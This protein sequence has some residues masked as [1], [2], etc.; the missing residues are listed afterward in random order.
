[1]DSNVKNAR[2]K[3]YTFLRKIQ[4]IFMDSLLVNLA[5]FLA[6]MF[7]T[8]VSSIYSNYYYIAIKLAPFM[9][10]ISITVFA[11]FKFYRILWRHAT[12]NDLFNI[13]LANM[14]ASFATYIFVVILRL[15][16]VDYGYQMP[17]VAFLLTCFFNIALTGGV[18]M[19]FRMIIVKDISVIKPDN[20]KA[21]YRNA[22]IIGASYMGASVV[23]GM[24]R[25]YYGDI[26]PVVIIDDHPDRIGASMDGIPIVTSPHDLKHLVEKYEI[27]EIVI[28]IITPQGDYGELV[29]KCVET[30]C[31]VRR[32]SPLEETKAIGNSKVS[33]QDIDVN[34]LLGRKESQL[35]TQS[36]AD[37][38][39]GKTVLISGG[40][41]SIGGE[42]CRIL[43]SLSTSP[44]QIILYDISENYMYD[45]YNE[46]ARKYGAKYIASVL[47]LRVGSVRDEFRLSK[48]FTQYKPEIV[49]H[50]AAHKHV[51]LMEDSPFEAIKNNV[52]GTYNIAKI[53]MEYNV[54]RFLLV[55]TDKAVNPTN[56]MGATKRMA[57]MIL[58]S[59]K[60]KS[61]TDFV[62]VR[63]GNVLG[64]HGSVV[65]LFM[66]QINSGGPITLTH[67][68]IIRYFM[69]IP[70]A[71]SLVL[72]AMA[73]ADGGELFVLD[74]GSPVKI[75]TLAERM[76]QLYSN[77][78]EIEIVY[79]GL[80]PGE[81]LYEELLLPKE[82]VIKTSNKQ[83]FI[84]HPEEFDQSLIKSM[85]DELSNAIAGDD[86]T[87]LRKIIKKYVPTY[88]NKN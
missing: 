33:L 79:T 38:V 11:F 10:I 82:G 32:I 40:G 73:L 4:W 75:K 62:A 35:D 48:I 12:T 63:F 68:E 14:V 47:I 58:S 67:P 1:M 84:T 83:I 57:E 44:K 29:D 45:L 17:D 50:A 42:L 20:K 88:V 86:E 51:P 25:G 41:G 34:D 72:Q 13:I 8:A 54:K 31:K 30:G 55:S 36:V 15:L 22:L 81:K 74:M 18:R 19:I 60:G 56:V 16:G 52:L 27:D 76:I 59:F 65:P 71:A 46:M 64:S 70:E 85:I 37:F 87:N 49:L 80:R 23:H 66:N 77:D 61:N 2:Q 7:L 78:N 6:L 39:K 21:T 28:T 9:T 53:S 24:M 3:N 26:R 69:T 5:L 43:L